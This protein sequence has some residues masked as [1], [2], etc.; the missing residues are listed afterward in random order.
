[1]THAPIIQKIDAS[2]AARDENLSGLHR[3]RGIIAVIAARTRR[4][5]G[6]DDGEDDIPQ[7]IREELRH[8]VPKRIGAVAE[9]GPRAAFSTASSLMTQPANRPQAVLTTANYTMTVKGDD[10]VDGRACRVVAIAA[11]ES[12]PYLF[13]GTIWVDAQDGSIVQVGGRGIEGRF[14]ACRRHPGVAPVRQ[15]ERASHGDPC[16]GRGRK[17]AAGANHHRHRLQRLRDGA[18]RRHREFR[19]LLGRQV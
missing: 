6:A 11:E 9:G 19:K 17:L 7:G 14:R 12:S 18:S 8:R 2:V 4:T 10:R 5:R 16:D 13:R 15:H 1:M 3:H